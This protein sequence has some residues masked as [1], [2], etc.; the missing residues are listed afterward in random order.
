MS[1][2]C[3][4]PNKNNPAISI[5]VPIYNAEDYLRRCLDSLMKQVK[6]CYE[7]I[8]VNDGSTDSSGHICDEYASIYG[9]IS[10]IHQK[11]KGISSARNAGMN[12]ANGKWIYFIDSDDFLLDNTL[13]LLYS[14][15]K[16]YPECDVI[17]GAHNVVEY[18]RPQ[19]IGLSAI[20]IARKPYIG[21]IYQQDYF[22]NVIQKHMFVMNTMFRRDFLESNS[23]RFD[24]GIFYLED[25]EFWIR[26]LSKHPKCVY[27]GIASYVYL[28]K[29]PTSLCGVPISDRKI[30]SEIRTAGSIYAKVACF[31]AKEAHYIED[32]V[33][34][35]ALTAFYDICL[36]GNN[37]ASLVS[38]LKELFPKIRYRESAKDK[39]VCNL[40]NL[41]PFYACTLLSMATKLKRLYKQR[42]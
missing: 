11:N 40:Y 27:T 3:P 41:S 26:L 35:L 33:N 18:A 6:V 5:I 29:R 19:Q 7:V 39:I 13:H 20:D 30:I 25:A 4:P 12:I 17:Q 9:N 42:I 2:A 37:K 36:Y 15:V 32:W 8:L 16:K 24:Q 21:K 38:K 14:E 22:C 31:A 34:T 10:V 1:V 28:W 23:L